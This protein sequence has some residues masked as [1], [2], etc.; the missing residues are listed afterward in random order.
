MKTP[1]TL[2]WFV[3]AAV[4]LAVL[5]CATTPT[6]EEAAAAAAAAEEV[7][8]Q[9]RFDAQM[10]PFRAWQQKFESASDRRARPAMA[11]ARAAMG[12]AD[13]NARAM[14][15]ELGVEVDLAQ[16]NAELD[17]LTKGLAELDAHGPGIA[18]GEA[19]RGTRLGHGRA[20]AAVGRGLELPLPRPERRHLRV[21]P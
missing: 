17:A 13:R 5:G 7:A 10:A 16:A 18:V 6:P 12:F 14:G 9:E 21:E 2:R 3:P 20:V 19:H 4:S 15:I 8:R 11:E 1:A